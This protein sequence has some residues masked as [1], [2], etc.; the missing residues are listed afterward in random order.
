[1]KTITLKKLQTLVENSVMRFLKES[2]GDITYP[3]PYTVEYKIST[4]EDGEK[5]FIV[6]S[7]ESRLGGYVSNSEGNEDIIYENELNE[8]FDDYTADMI[9]KGEYTSMKD[10]GFLYLDVDSIMESKIDNSNIKSVDKY[11]SWKFGTTDEP[12][13]FSFF[14]LRNGNFI[15]ACNDG[16]SRG[17]DHRSIGAGEL[18]LFDIVSL[19]DIR[20]MPESPGLSLG[21]TR[22]SYQQLKAL[23]EWIDLFI[24]KGKY[25]F[26]IDILDNEGGDI[27]SATIYADY[28]SDVIDAIEYYYDHGSF[29]PNNEDD[30]DDYYNSPLQQ[31][32]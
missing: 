25:T 4:D 26:Y 19:G 7:V 18:K 24:R 2:Y 28:S 10:N 6:K 3:S 15:T 14:L 5:I 20:L 9:S 12:N 13:Y 16:Y 29:T 21:K 27:D 23:S 32:R 1:M 11:L 30:D 8:Y 22:P 17:E 31:F